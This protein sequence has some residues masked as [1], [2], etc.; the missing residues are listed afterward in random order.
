MAQRDF[1][2]GL[3]GALTIQ[4]PECFSHDSFTPSLIMVHL[5]SRKKNVVSADERARARLHC[6]ISSCSV[7]SNPPPSKSLIY[8]WNEKE[9]LG[10][11][12]PSVQL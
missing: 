6:Q 1:P 9:S 8:G 4:H 10:V 3:S 11:P 12:K 2:K 5:K 7:S